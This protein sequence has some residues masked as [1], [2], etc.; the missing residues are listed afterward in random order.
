MAK[1]LVTGGAGFIGSHIVDGYVNNGHQVVIVDD[2]STGKKEN[3]NRKARFYRV[4]L[5]NKGKI[6]RVIAREKPDII[7]HQA[8]Q[9]S[10]T[11]SVKDPAHDAEINI[12]G[13]LNL[14][15]AAKENTVKKVIFAST[16]GA[17]YGNT[18]NIPTTEEEL[19]QPASPYAITKYACEN[20]LRFYL[21]TAGVVPVVLRYSNVFGPRQDPFGEA[22]VVA[23]FSKLIAEGKPLTVFGDGKQTRDYVFVEDVASANLMA[24]DYAPKDFSECM[25]NIGTGVE[26]DLLSIIKLLENASGKKAEISFKPVRLGDLLRSAIDPTKA[27]K[28]LGWQAQISLSDA[29][30][31]TYKYFSGGKE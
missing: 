2:L 19:P 24:I 7:N 8:A 9:K 28:I 5:R 17:I 25:C 12:L 29:I 3:I 14:I 11:D 4:D 6:A 23:I 31:K 15:E 13:F 30:A 27:H 16:G 21:E 22:G 26:T 18:K 1:I 20:Y 10:V